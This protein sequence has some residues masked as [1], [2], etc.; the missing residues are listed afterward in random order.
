MT[1]AHSFRDPQLAQKLLHLIRERLTQSWTIMEVCGGQTHQFIQYGIDQ[2]LPDPI[3]LIHGPGC[4]VCVTPI[5]AIDQALILAAKKEVIFCS[6]GDMLRVPGSK[7]DLLT[8]KAQGANIR[9]IYSPLEIISIAQQ[10]PHSEIV[11]F[12]VGFETTA[13]TTALLALQ[14]QQ[15]QLKN[16]SLLVA[17]VCV[18]PVLIQLLTNPHTSVQA[19]L[20][21]GHVCAIMGM[22][23]YQS[24]ARD[25]QVPIVVTG[26]EPI[27]LLHGIYQAI[28]QLEQKQYCVTNA[29]SRV[30]NSTGNLL[31]QHH[32]NKVFIKIDRYWR[33]LGLIPNSGLGLSSEFDFCNAEKKFEFT[34]DNAMD[35]LNCRSGE[36]LQG[37][38]K[39]PQCAEFAR[40]CHPETPL[41]ATMVSNEGACAAYYRYRR[42]TI[43]PN[44]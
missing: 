13:P 3:R 24:I 22:Q 27:D 32:L 38:I 44:S 31:A 28:N 8:L 10:Y 42:I 23:Q 26:F 43:G 37:L 2:L 4:P 19:F 9:I 40:K 25:Y 15:L 5:Q 41:G 29:Y 7:T 17:H 1:L 18:P 14:A 35:N 12:A 30:V 36:I 20:A 21:A 39:P 34:L 16:I 33:G 6:F 11:F